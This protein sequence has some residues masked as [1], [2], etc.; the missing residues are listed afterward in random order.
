MKLNSTQ[1]RMVT[2][3]LAFSPSRHV[4]NGRVGLSKNLSAMCDSITWSCWRNLGLKLWFIL[5]NV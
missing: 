4:F 2:V 5:F 1:L 3:S